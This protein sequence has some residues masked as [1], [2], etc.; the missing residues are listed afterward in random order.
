MK[1]KT[2]VQNMFPSQFAVLLLASAISI[3]VA[4]Q[5]SQPSNQPQSTPPAAT[6][7]LLVDLIEPRTKRDSGAM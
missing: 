4:A 7:A 3:P 2:V 6:A 5:Q 1:T